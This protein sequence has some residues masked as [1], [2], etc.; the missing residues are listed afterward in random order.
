[1]ASSLSRDTARASSKL[2][3]LAQAIS[4]TRLT[5][6]NNSQSV[7]RTSPTSGRSGSATKV[8]PLFDFGYCS[9]NWRPI[10][11]GSQPEARGG[12]ADN[13]VGPPFENKRRADSCRSS[14]ESPLP[15]AVANDDHRSRAQPVFFAAERAALYRCDAQ[16]GEKIR[17]Y[18]S[19]FNVLG[20]P[21]R[22]HR[23]SAAAPCH[24]I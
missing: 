2:A 7:E 17:R 15:Q 9:A 19:A 12:H 6:P 5:A 18:L 22:A 16:E 20:I 24:Q 10:N 13:R 3:T 11:F 21:G 4:S 8:R 23:A 1:M 14:A